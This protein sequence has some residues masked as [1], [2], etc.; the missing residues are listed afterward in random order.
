ML[1]LALRRFNIQADSTWAGKAD[2][3]AAWR[4][5]CS[6]IR[7]EEVRE[8]QNGAEAVSSEDRQL[9]A[10]CKQKAVCFCSVVL[11]HNCAL[12]KPSVP[13]FVTDRLSLVCHAV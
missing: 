11:I 6:D 1:W 7:R 3:A 10:S 4:S 8:A 9:H 5:L 12:H 2:A 13:C